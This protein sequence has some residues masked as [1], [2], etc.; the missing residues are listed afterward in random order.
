MIHYRQEDLCIELIREIVPMLAEYYRNT[1]AKQDIPPY[2]FEWGQYLTLQNNSMLT[3]TV[4]R[5][6]DKLIGFTLYVRTY[7]PHHKTLY[8]AECDTIAVDMHYRGRGVGR[9]LYQFT[10]GVLK[11]QGV[12]QIINRY[13]ECYDTKPMF[14]SLGFKAIERVYMKEV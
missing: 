6:Y 10:E 12:R 4:A 7:Q 8:I 3:V 1:V 11:A 14:E 9:G 5:D 13:R 2:D